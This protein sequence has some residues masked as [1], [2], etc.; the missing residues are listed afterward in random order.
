MIGNVYVNIMC[1]RH[2]FIDS[3]K[4]GSNIQ[5]SVLDFHKEI[6]VSPKIN[7]RNIS[8]I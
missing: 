6:K 4:C 8:N 3:S 5:H 7:P 2:K 1:I